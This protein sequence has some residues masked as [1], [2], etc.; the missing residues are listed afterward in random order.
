M[1]KHLLFISLL[2]ASA[3]SAFADDL[4]NTAISEAGKAEKVTSATTE[5]DADSVHWKFP[6]NFSVNFSHAG[7]NKN[8]SAGGTNNI[9]YNTII[10]LNANYKKNRHVWNNNLFF[11]YGGMFSDD[12][13]NAPFFNNYRKTT[14]R[15]ELFSKY[16]L[17]SNKFKSL[18]YSA[19]FDF[20]TQ[21]TPGYEYTDTTKTQVSDLLT[22][23]NIIL[24]LGMDYKPNKFVS[25]YLSPL[26]GR[27][28]CVRN[29]YGKKVSYMQHPD[30]T[31]LADNKL[32]KQHGDLEGYYLNLNEK[33][34]EEDYREKYGFSK[35]GKDYKN[36]HIEPSLGAYLRITNDFDIVKNIHLKSNLD[37]F[38]PYT[39]WSFERYSYLRD[40]N[41]DHKTHSTY[42]FTKAIVN[43]DVLLSMKITKYISASIHTQYV[44]DPNVA[45]DHCNVYTYKGGKVHSR[46]QFM[47]QYN[48]GFA[49]SF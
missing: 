25:V 15:F 33:E 2:S 42:F 9:S 20:K 30:S 26:T 40:K 47:H 17:Q 5:A 7:F 34:V 12:F 45:Y 41:N 43:W 21:L 38:S 13:D 35:E 1:M 27:F 23:A 31:A 48:I 10:D 18:Y 37:F 44:F 6:C 16:G 4:R 19:L 3:V 32:V 29:H 36:A 8:W 14:D 39:P 28:V 49:Y 11:E 46:S 24:S 22:P